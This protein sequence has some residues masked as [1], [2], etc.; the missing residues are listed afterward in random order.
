MNDNARSA[1]DAVELLMQD[2]REMESLFREFEYRQ[3]KHQ[4]LAGVV[5]AVCAEIRL[6]DTLETEFF[7]PAVD[8]LGEAMERLTGECE[9]EH[10]TVLELVEKV[11]QTCSDE[12]RRDAHFMRIIQ[13]MKRHIAF[14]E[15]TLF[16]AVL[17]LE[18]LDLVAI[19]SAMIGR[20]AELAAEAQ[21]LEAAGE[22]A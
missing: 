12:R 10:D 17:N 20:K 5:A 8:T 19:A 18:K 6:H 2:H 14:E 15:E 1:L 21:P 4:A 16:P 11:E 7:Y 22:A 9:E 13:H 3:Q